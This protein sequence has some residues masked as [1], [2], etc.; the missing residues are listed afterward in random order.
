PTLMDIIR[1]FFNITFMQSKMEEDGA[2]VVNKENPVWIANAGIYSVWKSFDINLMGKYV[3]PF[4][5]DR[6][7]SVADGPQ[8]LGDFFVLDLNGGY[9]TKWK[10]PV[11]FYLRS[12]NLTNKIYSTVNGYP[13]FGRMIHAGIQVKFTREHYH[14]CLP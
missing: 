5:N 13:D 10:T 4:E 8:P 1:P 7:V 11:R 12:K 2:L 6:F 9:T 14:T 3:S